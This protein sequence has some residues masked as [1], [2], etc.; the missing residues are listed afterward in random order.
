MLPMDIQFEVVNRLVEY[1]QLK[2]FS[3]KFVFDY[4]TEWDIDDKIFMVFDRDNYQ[5]SVEDYHFRTWSCQADME[6]FM[7]YEA[8]SIWLSSEQ[9]V[10]QAQRIFLEQPYMEQIPIKKPIWKAGTVWKF[11]DS[12]ENSRYNVKDLV[13]EYINVSNEL[14]KKEQ[15]LFV[16]EFHKEKI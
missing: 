9:Q 7:R 5:F 14:R 8:H 3:W 16:L 10:E 11:F 12:R 1:I 13:Y 4:Y 6:F 2:D 15:I